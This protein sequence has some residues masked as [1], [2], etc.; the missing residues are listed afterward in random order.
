MRDDV[1]INHHRTMRD[2]VCVNVCNE[3][4]NAQAYA[5]WCGSYVQV[6]RHANRQDDVSVIACDQ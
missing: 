1:I 6:I 2:D 5:D 4:R 3:I